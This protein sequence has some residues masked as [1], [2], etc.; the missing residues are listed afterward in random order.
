MF[1][2]YLAGGGSMPLRP[3]AQVGPNMA[4][5]LWCAIFQIEGKHATGKCHLL[6]MYTENSQQL[7]CNFCRLVGHDENTIEAM[8]R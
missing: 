6:Q 7:F 3:E 8:I 2:N 1:M 4:L 5:S